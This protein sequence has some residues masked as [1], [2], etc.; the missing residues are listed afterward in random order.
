MGCGKYIR[1]GTALAW[2]VDECA[3]VSRRFQRFALA[4]IE[5]DEDRL[6]FVIRLSSHQLAG[7]GIPP[8]GEVTGEVERLCAM[9]FVAPSLTPESYNK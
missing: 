4:A 1:F 3:L 8:T 5:T 7:M 2:R 9:I 6:S